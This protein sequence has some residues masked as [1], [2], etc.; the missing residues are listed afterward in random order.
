MIERLKHIERLP[1]FPLPVVLLPGMVMPLH[2]FEPRYRLML[3]DCLQ[4][5]RLFGLTYH[6]ESAVG[7]LVV[8]VVGSVGCAAHIMSV[9]PL[10]EERSDILTAG[11]CR[12]KTQEYLAQD[13]YLTARIEF[14]ED[15]AEEMEVPPDLVQDVSDLFTRFLKAMR[16][17]R[18][19]PLSRYALPDDLELLSFAIASAVLTEPEEQLE[20]LQMQSTEERFQL[21][22]RELDAIIEEIESRAQEH[23][24]M[25]SNGH[26]KQRLSE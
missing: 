3:Q 18:D 14:F 7:S 8:P 19:A 9:A 10:P 13:P 21:L 16:T 26:R 15:D 4:G 1:I 24:A 17:L 6:A 12:Y 23:L 2:I 22:G 25:R 5:Q 20:V 11:L